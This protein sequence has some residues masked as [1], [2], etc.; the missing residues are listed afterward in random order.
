MT[1]TQTRVGLVAAFVLAS[2]VFP[3]TANAQEGAVALEEIVVTARRVEE[4]LQDVPLAITAFSA[5]EIQAAGI[6]NLNDVADLT[7]G[8]T[9][10]NLIGEFLPVPVI[11]SIAPTAVQDR[12]NNAAIFVDGVY[13]S[14]REGL[15]FSQLDLERIEVV[16]G[17]QA[18][19]YGRNSFSGAVNFVTA[20]PTDE[21]R[22][23]AE[24]TF[25][26]RGRMVASGAISGPL[27]EDKLRARVAIIL[28]QWDGSYENQ[29][30]DG[31][32]IGG[33]EYET[34]QASLYWTPT[35]QFEAGLSLY[36]SQDQI[37]VSALTSVTATCENVSARGVR[38]ANYCGELPSIGKNDL[39]VLERAT[40]EERDVERAHLTMKLDT[41]LGEF[42]ALSGFSN[43]EQTFLYDG[44]RGNPS[45]RFAYQSFISPFPRAFVL[46]TFDAE[47]LQIGAADITEEFSQELRFTSPEDRSW[48][49]SLGAYFYSVEKEEGNSGVA[50]QTPRPRTFANFCPCIQFFPGVGFALTAFPRT[51]IGDLTF[52]RWFSGPMGDVTG[53]VDAM[54]ETDAW[55]VFGSVDANFS[56]R[57]KG[58]VELR[59]TDEEKHSQNFVTGSDLQNSWDF[60][61]WRATMDFKPSENTM[62]YA[63]IAGAEKS[64]AFDSDNEENINGEDVF[65]ASFIDPEKNTSFE[66][67]VKGTYMGG[68]LSADIALFLIDWTEIVIPQLV[69]V[70][71]NGIPLAGVLNLD[72]NAGDAT[73]QGVEASFGFAVTDNLTASLGFSVTDS[74]FDDAKIQSFADFPSY[75]PD[76][77]VSGNELL[78]QSAVQSNLTLNYRRA[79]RN[80]MEW[81][82]RTDVLYTGKQWVGAVNQAEV[83]A[84]TY[85]NLKI[86]IDA[87]R[88]SVEL[89]SDNLLDDDKPIAA[90]RDVWFSNALPGGGAGG[91]FDTFFPWRL[92]VSHPRRRQVGATLRVNF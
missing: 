71:S 43:V 12:E 57:L 44:S 13:V 74:E 82:V 81:Y 56:D 1:L 53:G 18:A 14:G 38:L 37:D 3:G 88:Y 48:R 69:G 52:G 89:W 41:A 20:R 27:V 67:G 17:P 47:L 66:L 2:S 65:V 29:V 60:I 72:M 22:G 34:V 7:P 31:P 10:S 46:G 24:L 45:T 39:H 84:H 59:W 91:F 68:R 70:D 42:S 19:L 64:G 5:A 36:V 90:F 21:F 76:G 63:S 85:V 23:K 58:R 16:K 51:S 83:P 75:A 79:F 33:F 26:D 9:F 55:S 73:V 54:L 11:R 87:E 77:D 49:Y 78:R 92:T 15:N 32:D 30:P 80:D 61:S 86:G 35:E 50:A 62:Y 25:G 6:E 8:M 28:N 40:G 4:R